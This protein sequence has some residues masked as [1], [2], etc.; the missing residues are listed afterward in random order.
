LAAETVELFAT[1]LGRYAG[2]L[3]LIF[4][5]SGGVFIGGG[6]APV[7]AA[8][9]RSGGFRDAFVNK[10]PREA[11]WTFATRSHAS[12]GGARRHPALIAVRRLRGG[13]EAAGALTAPVTYSVALVGCA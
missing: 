7:I 12:G 2:D 1:Y 5:P 4:M 8:R 3:A 13:S 10:P 6:I 11:S 9:L